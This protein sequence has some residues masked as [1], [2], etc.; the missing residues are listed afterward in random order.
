L[1][2]SWLELVEDPD[3]RT[4]AWRKMLSN[5]AANPVTALTG[6]PMGVLQD[7]EVRELFQVLLAEAV[8]VGIAEGAKLGPRRMFRPRWRSTVSSGRKPGPRCCMTGWPAG[9][10][11]MS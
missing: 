7:A 1:K 6:R 10:W 5:V 4:A 9:S 3:F 2:G 11:R 8:A